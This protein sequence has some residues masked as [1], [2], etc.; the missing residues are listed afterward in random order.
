M[1]VEMYLG[2]SDYQA[3]TAS[4][5]LSNRIS[6]Y[7]S[8]QTS[9]QSFINTG[10]LQGLTYQSAKN[11]SSQILIPLIQGCILLDEA[12]KEACAKLPREYRSQVDS[13]DLREDELR[14]KI[15]QAGMMASRYEYLSSLERQKDKP[16]WSRESDLSL[17]ARRYM[18]VER[19][20][21]EKLQKLLA[22]NSQSAQYFASAEP[23]LASV[24][25]GLNQCRTSWDARTQSFIIP[26]KKALSW[27][28]DINNKW[29]KRVDIVDI[30]IDYLIK[31]DFIS[32]G[33]GAIHPYAKTT[34]LMG[35]SFMS[36]ISKD[37][38][39]SGFM[40]YGKLGKKANENLQT[41]WRSVKKLAN[42]KNW[43][44]YAK[45]G[46][47]WKKGSFNQFLSTFHHSI[48]SKAANFKVFG[49]YPVKNINSVL[50]KMTDPIKTYGK[51]LI[52]TV[53]KSKIG[54]KLKFVGKAAKV[55]GW[56]AVGV[57]V[58]V[59]S[60]REFNNKDSRAYGSVGK[61]LIHAG[62]A[63]LKS[64]G[65]IEGA[66][67]GAKAGPWGALAG[68]AAGTINTVWGIVSPDT[69]NAFYSGV[70]NVL[71]DGYD[72]I[73]D[74]VGKAVKGTWNSVTSW[75]GGGAKY[76]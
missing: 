75:F 62:V 68:F 54:S 47:K 67:I 32:K 70:Q 20:L 35:K 74:G 45:L 52:E 72:F 60:V 38:K 65:P 37:Y 56:V 18:E 25:Q 40:K 49:K 5:V 43:K 48:T 24:Q 59:T 10:N 50:G 76:A 9:L 1:G 7:K 58:T 8:I 26:D 2:Q 14:E 61:S 15:R 41:A 22:F 55:L 3:G 23:L 63:Q 6:A 36:A 29:K 21:Q 44:W 64:A 11:Y 4:S 19:R 66:L 13:I 42:K 12:V 46:S 28:K 51:K 57:D 39:K 17:I 71:D 53:S 33:A 69:K 27:V 31:P 73:A 30:G 16:N 34:Y